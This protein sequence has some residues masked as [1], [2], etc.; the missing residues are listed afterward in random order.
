MPKGIGG[1]QSHNPATT[2]WLTPPALIQGLGGAS[3]FDLDPCAAPAQPWA[4]AKRMVALP[5]DGLASD[6][7]GRVWL[8]PPYS[9]GEVEAWLQRLGDHGEGTAL[10]FARTDTE[11]FHRQVWSRA[12]GLLFLE[13]RLHF[14][15]ADGTR[16]KA[17]SGAPSVLCAYGSQDLDILFE[18]GLAGA[19]VPLRFPRFILVEPL[20]EAT[21]REIV[22]EALGRQGGSHVTVAELYR[23]LARHP[24]AKGNPS[25]KAKVRQT[26]QRG[27]FEPLGAGRWKMPS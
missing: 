4:T 13:G 27:P 9:T 19:L 11:C 26:L 22:G 14:H 16:A 17:N 1:H 2:T 20:S 12:S 6:W 18:S 23:A 3:S 10:I 7:D 15:H 21:W 8:N 5:A 25:W 24:K